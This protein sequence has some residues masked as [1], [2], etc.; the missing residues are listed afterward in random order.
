MEGSALSGALGMSQ[1]QQ[2]QHQHQQQQQQ[3]QAAARQ[4]ILHNNPGEVGSDE[5]GASA[6]ASPASSGGGG[7]AYPSPRGYGASDVEMEGT[8]GSRP[9]SSAGV[10]MQRPTAKRLAS[11]VL[12]SGNAKAMKYDEAGGTGSGIALPQ[13]HTVGQAQPPALSGMA[14]L[15]PLSTQ[16]LGNAMRAPPPPSSAPPMSGASV[17]GLGTLRLPQASGLAE[18]RKMVPPSMSGGLGRERRVSDAH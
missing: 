17:V 18:R 13:L 6:S 16:N 8:G 4:F 7:S 1:Q 10:K 3:K 2:H 9:T 11:S 14:S 12:E 5:S 15:P